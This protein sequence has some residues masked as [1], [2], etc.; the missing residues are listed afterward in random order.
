MLLMQHVNTRIEECSTAHEV[1]KSVSDLLASRWVAEAW[2]KVSSETINRC[3]RKAG[4][5]VSNFQVV[6]RGISLDEDPFA[7][8]EVND[9]TEEL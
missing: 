3:F 2:Q 7:E 9:D 8:L 6:N 5:L 4:V 1:V